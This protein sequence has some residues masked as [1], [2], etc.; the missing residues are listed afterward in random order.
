MTGKYYVIFVFDLYIL[1][2]IIELGSLSQETV[3]TPSSEI[4][5]VIIIIT[6]NKFYSIAS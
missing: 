6:L 2:M 4:L 3:S 1:L 5:Y